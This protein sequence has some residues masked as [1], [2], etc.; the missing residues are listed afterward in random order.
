MSQDN[1]T[2][3]EINAQWRANIEYLQDRM[4]V[5]IVAK[6][7]EVA[8]HFVNMLEEIFENMG[9]P[10]A[11]AVQFMINQD[12]ACSAIDTMMKERGIHVECIDNDEDKQ[13]NGLYFYKDGEIAHCI[14]APRPRRDQFL[15]NVVELWS[16]V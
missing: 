9:M 2:L 3:E 6:P 8:R 15:G 7:E 1:R 10:V 4:K 14:L 12:A 13:F 16:T 11:A 5:R